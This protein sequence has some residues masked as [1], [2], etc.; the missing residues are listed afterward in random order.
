MNIEE[1]HIL[2]NKKTAVKTLIN[3][4]RDIPD[5]RSLRQ[6]EQLE[7]IF[8]ELMKAVDELITADTEF[9]PEVMKI[10][11]ELGQCIYKVTGGDLDLRDEIN[12]AERFFE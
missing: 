9:D 12:E 2:E 4:M 6:L 7:N 10:L 1:R 8:D 3:K 11:R 5:D